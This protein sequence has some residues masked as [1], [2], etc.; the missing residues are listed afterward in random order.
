MLWQKAIGGTAAAKKQFIAV[1]HYTSPYI[2]AYPWSSSGFGTK[3]TNPAT[4]PTGSGNAVAFSGD[5]TAIAVAHVNSPYITAYPW[6]SSG[7]GTKFTNPT[8]LPT[9]DG[10]GVAFGEI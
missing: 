4:L 3:F 9:G 5:G 8:T 2:T 1:A 6:S 7:F 10:Y